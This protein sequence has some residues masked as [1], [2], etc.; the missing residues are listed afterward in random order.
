MFKD[1]RQGSQFYILHKTNSPYCEVGNIVSVVNLRAK[2]P[3]FTPY[4]PQFPQEMVVD[5]T[6]K[7]GED[8]VKL[9][10]VS[11]EGTITDYKPEG[12]DKMVLACD[13]NSINSEINAMHQHSQQ[14]LSSIESHK[15]IIEGCEKMLN[16][17]NP[18]FAKEKA[19]E[20]KIKG[21]EREL[22]EMK[23]MFGGGISELKQLL[24]DKQS[25]NNK[26]T[27]T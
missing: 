9:S 3:N 19:Q 10:S 11:A 7:I 14:V 25:N 26:K 24:L 6:V 27:T 22:A 13:L 15:S 23:E 2:N 20:E 1:L 5:I 21:L 4:P 16:Q 12:G 8:N 18:Q 17:L